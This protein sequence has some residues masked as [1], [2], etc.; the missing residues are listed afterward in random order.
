MHNSFCGNPSDLHQWFL[1]LPLDQGGIYT[2]TVQKG[3]KTAGT[4][5]QN[6]IFHGLLTEAW[7]S[8]VFSDDS[9][10]DMKIRFKIEYGQAKTE[11]LS[12]RGFDMLWVQSW[13]AMN[14]TQRTL[15]IKGLISEMEVLGATG[16]IIDGLIA[17]WKAYEQ[18]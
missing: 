14:K 5:P 11:V 3:D 15:A 16:K 6:K 18:A 4:D 1:K 10:Q 2:I 12:Y 8:G 7:H 9:V 13:S 17:E